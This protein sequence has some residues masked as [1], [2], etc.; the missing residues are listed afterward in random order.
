[1]ES[2]TSSAKVPDTPGKCL[3]RDTGQP[4]TDPPCI[5]L[6]YPVRRHELGKWADDTACQAPGPRGHV[7]EIRSQPPRATASRSASRH[8][9]V[10]IPAKASITRTTR[11]PPG[12][13]RPPGTAA[14]QPARSYGNSHES[15]FNVV[16]VRPLARRESSGSIDASPASHRPLRGNQRRI[17]AREH[18]RGGDWIF[19][20]NNG[21]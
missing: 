13:P 16:Q 15:V 3:K 11:L 1:M 4:I 10:E 21:L 12:A 7:P 6:T 17:P 18:G 20:R 14:D 8:E 2:R 5:A 19:L 9:R